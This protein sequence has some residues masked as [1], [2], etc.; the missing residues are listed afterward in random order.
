MWAHPYCAIVCWCIYLFFCILGLYIYLPTCLIFCSGFV[1]CL[2][3]FFDKLFN[4]VTLLYLQV[5]VR[6][7]CSFKVTVCV[8]NSLLSAARACNVYYFGQDKLFCG[9]AVFL[10]VCFISQNLQKTNVKHA[11]ISLKTSQQCPKT[12]P[13]ASLKT[14]HASP[15]KGPNSSQE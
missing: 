6:G 14:S 9:V 12:F 5:L 13:K 10:L 11:K 2:F 4:F 3:V 8:H 1:H 15:P 7:M